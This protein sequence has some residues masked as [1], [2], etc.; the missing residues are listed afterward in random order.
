MS[1]LDRIERLLAEIEEF[2]A[3]T[4]G[5]FRQASDREAYDIASRIERKMRQIQPNGGKHAHG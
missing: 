4:K 5:L 1:D 3:A 2:D